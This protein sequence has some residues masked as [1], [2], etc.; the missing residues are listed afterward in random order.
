MKLYI[1]NRPLFSS[2]VPDVEENKEAHQ[3]AFNS[4]NSNVSS[5]SIPINLIG[6]YGDNKCAVFQFKSFQDEIYFYE[7][8]DLIG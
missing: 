3:S 1:T 7:F 6:Y 4:L 5:N 2:I 8:K